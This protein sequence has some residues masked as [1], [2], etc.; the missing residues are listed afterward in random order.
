M[1]DQASI[2]VWPDRALTPAQAANREAATDLV[3]TRHGA[4]PKNFAEM[5][6]YAKFMST[7]KGAVGA[8]LMGNV[9]GCLAVMEIANQFDMPAYAVAR[10][11]YLV[12]GRVAFMGQFF[13]SIIEKYCP[14]KVGPNGRKLTWRYEGAGDTLKII[15]SGTFE[16]AS[17]PV[18]YESPMFKDIKVKN[19]P[20]WTVEP[21]R[22]FVYFGVRGWQ[23]MHWPEGMLQILTD[24]E[25]AAL[26]PSDT[27]R[28]ITPVS[29]SLVERLTAS[30]AAEG[31]TRQGFRGEIKEADFTETGADATGDVTNSQ[32]ATG[33]ANEVG[34]SQGQA[35]PAD[36][37]ETENRSAAAQ[38]GGKAGG[39]PATESETGEQRE[40]RDN[41]PPDARTG[42]KPK[43]SD[44]AS[45]TADAGASSALAVD[46]P[47]PD[48]LSNASAPADSNRQPAASEGGPAGGADGSRGNE[49]PSA[50]DR[51]RSYS[52][53]L[54]SIT[55]APA[56]LG[57]QGEAWTRRYGAFAG[58]DEDK[59][60]A[61]YAIHLNRLTGSTDITGCKKQ[62]EEIIGK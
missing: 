49:Q 42:E 54:L 41:G 55:D 30:R 39:K 62:V 43:S 15:V 23:T 33:G 19:S 9:G 21:R 17:E 50:S 61:I 28:D 47:Q 14:L 45:A 8:H 48:L 4:M 1:N 34:P 7:A 51:L 22:Q 35:R 2:D 53:A 27:A 12:N 58:A 38:E 3:V 31:D 5:V 59:R 20:L 25:A 46:S 57:K 37:S 32:A 24:D 6:D 40:A 60:K 16:G 29:S 36:A 11:S 52:K 18:E 13:H 26:P 44:Q 56:K 10:Q